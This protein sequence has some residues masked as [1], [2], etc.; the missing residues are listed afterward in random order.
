MVRTLIKLFL[1]LVII[2]F[3]FPTPAYAHLIGGNGFASG[4]T[5]PLLG[6]DHL[7]AM[8]AV[9]IIATQTGGKT[10]WIVPSTFLIFMVI[11]GLLAIIGLKVP[12]VETGIA[13]SVLIFG[14]LMT[15]SKKLPTHLAVL[16]VAIFAFF[17]GHSHGEEMPMIANQVLYITGFIF[18]TALL[19]AMG[20]LIG[21]SARKTN[22]TLKML[23]FSGAAISF[24]GICFLFAL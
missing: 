16:C 18:S 6:L 23:R 22:L 20:V 10:T 13:L 2:F 21:Y 8:I 24:A 9:G 5:H 17:H 19:H 14:A 3:V 15:L 1:S 12:L 11:G 4:L 7:L